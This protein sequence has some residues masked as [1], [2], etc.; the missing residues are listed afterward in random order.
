[1]AGIIVKA[2]SFNATYQY[3]ANGNR[4]LAQVTFVS[5][6]SVKLDQEG[7]EISP[8]D[9][10]GSCIVRLYP[11]PTSSDLLIEINGVTPADFSAQGNSIKIMNLNGQIVFETTKVMSLNPVDLSQIAQGTY[12][13]QFTIHSKSKTYKIV[14]N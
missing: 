2:Q 7:K 8:S 12:I 14:K 4:T 9:S 11:N 1:M 5:L 6:K 13:L 3:D 10:F